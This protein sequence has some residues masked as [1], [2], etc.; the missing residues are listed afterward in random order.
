MIAFYKCAS[1]IACVSFYR[2]RFFMFAFLKSLLMRWFSCISVEFRLR[3]PNLIDSTGN[4]TKSEFWTNTQITYSWHKIDGSFEF[5]FNSS[6]IPMEW[7]SQLASH[8]KLSIYSYT[9][10]QHS[11]NWAVPRWFVH[12]FMWCSF[13]ILLLL[14]IRV[15]STSFFHLLLL[16]SPFDF[17]WFYSTLFYA[18]AD[19]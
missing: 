9:S 5:P 1:C 12:L 17:M 18:I 10:N 3:C 11:A 6:I 14:F 13:C 15:S 8:R 2:V 19:G 16:L 7:W 4:K